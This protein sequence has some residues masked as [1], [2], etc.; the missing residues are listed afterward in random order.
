MRLA[1]DH[2][3]LAETYEGGINAEPRRR[4]VSSWNQRKML[5]AFP[6]LPSSRLRKKMG[7][8]VIPN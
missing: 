1:L 3:R 8:G 5:V 4:R 7:A 2:S 6:N